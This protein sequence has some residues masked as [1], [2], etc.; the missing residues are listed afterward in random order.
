MHRVVQSSFPHDTFPHL[1][2]RAL[3]QEEWMRM[4]QERGG[5]TPEPLEEENVFDGRWVCTAGLAKPIS[6]QSFLFLR[7]GD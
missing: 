6:D 1:T 5:P 4:K 2:T 3:P 7:S